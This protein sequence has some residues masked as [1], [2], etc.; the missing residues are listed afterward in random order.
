VSTLKKTFSIPVSNGLLEHCAVMKEAVWL[1]MWYID[2]T[3]KEKPDG[4]GTG[5]LVGAVL[6][7]MPCRDEDAASALGREVKTIRRWRKHLTKEGYIELK[8][9]PIGYKIWVKKSKKWVGKGADK[10]VQSPPRS[11]VP[12]MSDHSVSEL[13][14]VSNH[15]ESDCPKREVR[16]DISGTRL[17]ETGTLYRQNRDLTET[18]QKTKSVFVSNSRPNGG[19]EAE[20]IRTLTEFVIEIAYE[21]SECKILGLGTKEQSRIAATI[22]QER[23]TREALRAVVFPF[24]AEMDP[25]ALKTG[26]DKLATMLGPALRAHAQMEAN[27]VR[28]ADDIARSIEAGQRKAQQ[29]RDDLERKMA[30]EDA[31]A[32]GDPFLLPEPPQPTYG[33]VAQEI[34]EGKR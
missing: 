22:T 15:P 24:V 10:N 7:G 8:R 32:D 19:Q 16:K 30:E 26:G 20:E 23:P 12:K 14:Q 5:N 25:W 1:F 21:A 17:P 3:T 33:E 29:E 11:D 4:N 9:T 28:Q 2:K 27:A 18:E 6:G 34:F 31:L 13:P